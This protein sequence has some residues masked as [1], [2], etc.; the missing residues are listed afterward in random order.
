VPKF[1]VIH[2]MPKEVLK[3]ILTTPPE[4]MADSIE[5]RTFCSFDAYWVRS[6]YVLEQEKVYCEWDAKEAESIRKVFKKVPIIEATIDAIYEMRIIDAEDFR[7]KE[8]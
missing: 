6:W 5:L 1:I 2:T 8:V 3:G 4:E 7:K